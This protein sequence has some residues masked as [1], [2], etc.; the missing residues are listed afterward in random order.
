MII[1]SAFDIIS[2]LE[3]ENINYKTTGKNV[4]AGWIEIQCPFPNCSDHSFHCGIN[5]ETGFFSCWICGGKG[6]PVKLIKA[7]KECGWKK[8]QEIY[9]K[10]IDFSLISTEI[11][12]NL[13]QKLKLPKEFVWIQED[14]I[15]LSIYTY[16]LNRHFNP[17]KLVRQHKLIAPDPFF[18]GKFKYRL[19]IPVF[20]NNKI[21]NF[22]GR[23]VSDNGVAKYKACPNDQAEIQLNNLLY[24]IDDLPKKSPCV[25][26]EGVFDQWRLGAGSVASFGINI[27]AEQ[28]ELLR[29]KEPTSVFI[30]FDPDAKEQAEKAAQKIWFAPVEICQINTD[31]DPGDLS[32]YEANIIMKEL[33]G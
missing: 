25:I 6:H 4:T 5:P 10:Y 23:S 32:D 7:L 33:L 9:E 18:L 2:F 12:E 26:V 8:A 17:E 24:G 20:L 29:K 11:Q 13:V 31:K 1:P 15:P 3:D 21:V 16:L 27:S 19:I 22:I 14:K 30:L 28:I